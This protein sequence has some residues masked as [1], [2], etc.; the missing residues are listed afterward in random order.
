M[1]PMMS[2]NV[3]P[4]D[5]SEATDSED[6]T[7]ESEEGG[8]IPGEDEKIDGGDLE[9]LVLTLQDDSMPVVATIANDNESNMNE[10]LEEKLSYLLVDFSK[11]IARIMGDTNVM[12][13]SLHDLGPAHVPVHHSFELTNEKPNLSRCTKESSKA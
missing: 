6:F 5:I 2:E 9:E 13:A 8:L 7:S 12:A 4:R 1:L 3:Q 11:E 10:G